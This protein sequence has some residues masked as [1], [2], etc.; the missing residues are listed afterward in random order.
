MNAKQKLGIIGCGHLGTIIAGAVRDGYLPD[1]ELAFCCSHTVEHAERL[2]ADYGCIACHT[3]EEL[4]EHHPDV[5]VECASVEAVRQSALPA[6]K[7]GITLIPLS[8]GAFADPEFYEAVKET[9][10]QY[11]GMVYIPSGAVGG[12]DAL[13]TV[14]L[15]A[16]ASKETLHA[17]IETRKGP[18]SLKNT[19]LYQEELETAEKKVFHGTAKEAIAILPTKVNVAVAAALS[20][21]G[22][23]HTEVTITSVPGFVGDDHKI[24]AEINGIKAVSDTYS[25][26]SDIAAWSAVAL[27]QQLASNIRLF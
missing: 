1:Y 13:R 19:P 6:M 11:H 20:T 7:Q 26:N 8:V 16:E 24:T 23:E 22:P 3:A 14:S 2:A 4:I 21:A 10:A 18:A 25:A 15:M 9:A 17:G 5:I 27:L 12:F